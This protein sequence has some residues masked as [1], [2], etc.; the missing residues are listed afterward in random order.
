MKLNRHRQHPLRGLIPAVVSFLIGGVLLLSL[1]LFLVVA[2]AKPTF[3]VEADA[4]GDTHPGCTGITTVPGQECITLVELF[5]QTD[6]TNWIS[7]SNW[8]VFDSGNAPCDWYGVTCH[9]GRIS[10]LALASNQLSGTL[11]LSLGN[12]DGL[13]RLRLEKNALKGRIPPTICKLT[14]GLTDLSLAYN[15]LFTRWASVERCLQPH[16]NDWPATQTTM[17]TDLRITE[18]FTDALRLAWTPIPYSAD[19]GY[20]EIAVATAITGPFTV[21]GQTIDKSSSTFLVTGLEPGRTYYLTVRSYTSPHGDQPSAVWSNPARLVGVTPATSG[22]VLVAGYFAADNDL[23]D[24]IDFVVERFRLGTHLNPNV[25][26]VLLIDGRQDG[27]THVLEIAGGQ[28]TPSD[29]VMQHWGVNELDT[30]DPTVLAWFLQHGRTQFPA[31]RSIVTLIGHGVALAPEIVWGPS[32]VQAAQRDRPSNTIPPL[33]KEHDHTPSDITNRGYMSAV[34]VG[35]ALMAATENGA[36]PFDVIFFDQ[37]FQG[38]LDVLYEVRQTANVFV[39]SP[40]YA[41]LAAAY[42][43]YLTQLTP[44]STPEEIGQSI[45]DLYQGSL[46]NRHPNTIFWVRSGDI[47]AIADAVSELGDALRTATQAGENQKIANAVRQSQYVDTTQCGRQN[48]Q[49][50]PPDELIGIESLGARLQFEFGTGDPYGVTTALEALRTAMQSVEKRTRIGHPYIAPDEVWDYGNTLTVLAPL[51]RNAPA[52]VAWRASL[53]R[54][55]TPF[56]ATWTI[57]PSQ[58]VTVTAS[59]AYVKE[60]KWDEFLAEW[61]L[62]LAPTVGQWCH[63]I[64]PEQVVA[65]EAETLSLTVT[66]SGPGSVQLNWTPT[67]DS[68]AAGYWLYHQGPYDISWSGR[69]R[70]QADQNSVTLAGLEAG[71]HKFALLARNTDEELV[72]QSNEVTVEIHTGVDGEQRLFLPLVAR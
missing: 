33:P 49:L 58:T 11:P 6:G 30:A 9:E 42:H 46:D 61:Y 13:T 70:L 15:A 14:P 53:Y 48:L 18:F 32:A 29:A 55:D 69:R 50:G 1:Q 3:A 36:N 43:K 23:A 2:A 54:A 27:D 5:S 19:G 38:N 47:Q 20:Y 62:D 67:D 57:D 52:D 24:Q 64:P 40:N 35:Q 4:G 34:D 60:G 21:Q 31:E 37:C 56:T 25:Q 28:I 45:I 7:N 44:T 10:E 22:R 72:G 26:V 41:W 63:Y 66:L 16:E 17:V 12:L 65:D 59:L 39:A 71:A 8:L 51:P 68:S